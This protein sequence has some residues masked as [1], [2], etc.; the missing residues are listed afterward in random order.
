M[1]AMS[2]LSMKENYEDEYQD[3]VAYIDA[4]LMPVFM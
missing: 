2:M 3:K 4:L 1:A